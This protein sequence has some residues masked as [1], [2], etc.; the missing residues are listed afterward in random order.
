MLSLM[1]KRCYHSQIMVVVM[2]KIKE[3]IMHWRMGQIRDIYRDGVET[4]KKHEC[5][6]RFEF[7]GVEI[8]VDQTCNLELSQDDWSEIYNAV[9]KE[10]ILHLC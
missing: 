3:I 2:G 8:V 10:K 7:N 4:A 5:A 6:V 1:L 9:G